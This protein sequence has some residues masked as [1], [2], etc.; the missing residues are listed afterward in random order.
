VSSEVEEFVRYQIA[1]A[2]LRRYPFAHFYV[3]PV[4]PDEYYRELLARLP[5]TEVLTPIHET[6]T[7]GIVDPKSGEIRTRYEA[8]HIADL[9]V[10]EEDEA[11]RA[12]GHLWRDLASWLMDEP[13]RE[14]I[15]DKF[16]AAITERFGEG[17]RLVTDLDSRFVRDFASYRIPPHTDQP[18]KLVSL[19]FY[20]PADESLRQHGTAIYRPL[21]AD[22]RCEG[23]ARHDFASFS[24]IAT[25]P[26]LPNALFG[27][28]KTDRSF[29]GVEAIKDDGIERNVL[30]YNIYVRKAVRIAAPAA[31]SRGPW[32][33]PWSINRRNP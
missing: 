21:S 6:G 4:F 18:A 14:L 29:H 17:V 11:R 1:N 7:V 9:G 3:R 5:R 2:E 26:F 25:M 12:A 30:L 32:V 15:M 20:L 22:V 8:R 28:F 19:L 33:W 13:F 24:K 16:G 23:N 31:L 10:L 27:F